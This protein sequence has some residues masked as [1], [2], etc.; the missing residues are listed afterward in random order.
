MGLPV[1]VNTLDLLLV[2]PHFLQGLQQQ[3]AYWAFK[4]EFR[5]KNPGLAEL[6]LMSRC[7]QLQSINSS[8]LPYEEATKDAKGS[9]LTPSRGVILISLLSAK[10][11][12]RLIFLSL[13]IVSFPCVATQTRHN[14]PPNTNSSSSEKL[15]KFS[16]FHRSCLCQTSP[17]ARTHNCMRTA[18][19]YS[20]FQELQPYPC[21]C[22]VK[23]CTKI[24]LLIFPHMKSN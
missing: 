21:V 8:T 13:L 20:T 2:G 14:L 12:I 18:V 23:Y 7:P 9:G 1:L 10:Y 16:S 6:E 22:F 17:T 19:L 4:L 11:R 15:H 3:E 5:C 24:P